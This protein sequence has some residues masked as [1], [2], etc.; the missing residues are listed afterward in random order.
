VLKTKVLANNFK[1]DKKKDI[2]IE[3]SHSR[4]SASGL[5]GKILEVGVEGVT[6]PV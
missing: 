2:G 3:I 1:W 5:A 4:V 6:L